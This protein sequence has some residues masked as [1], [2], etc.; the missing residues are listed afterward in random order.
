MYVNDATLK[1]AEDYGGPRK[2]FFRLILAQIKETYFD[3]SI[4]ELLR[5]KYVT[6]G[7]ILG[8]F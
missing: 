8:K 5:E 1:V 2:E 4:R 6:I 3:N 7:I